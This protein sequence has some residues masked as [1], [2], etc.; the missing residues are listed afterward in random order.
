MPEP[1][2]TQPQEQKRLFIENTIKDIVLNLVDHPDVVK[3]I[4]YNKPDRPALQIKVH[5]ADVG[6]V[7]GYQYKTLDGF[8]KIFQAMAKRNEFNIDIE[9]IA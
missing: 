5:P 7:C 2:L 4:P 1:H 3:I 9:V 8:R 6:R